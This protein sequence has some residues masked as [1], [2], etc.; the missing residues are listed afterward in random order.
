[1]QKTKCCVC[2]KK[3][4]RLIEARHWKTGKLQ[5]FNEP[6]CGS[7]ECLKTWDEHA[8][9]AEALAEQQALM[10]MEELLAN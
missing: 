5:T 10:A 2:L 6:T 9:Q 1:M 8:I 4:A 3:D 7:S